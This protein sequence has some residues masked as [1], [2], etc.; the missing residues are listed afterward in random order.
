MHKRILTWVVFAL[1]AM[2]WAL[3][4]QAQDEENEGVAE[5]VMITPKA[6]QGPALEAAIR[7]FH[8]WMADKPGHFRYSWYQVQTGPHTG[9]YIA[10]TGDHNWADF[11]QEF[12]WEDEAN[13]KF[14]ADIL[15][16]VEHAERILTV[17]MKE[18]AHWPEEF[19][20]YTLFQLENWYVEPGRYG[21]FRAGLEKIH[22]AL[23]ENGY[24][25]YYGFQNTISGAKGNQITLVLPHKNYADMAEE[26]PSFYE[27]VSEALG[28]PEAFE[29]EM[30]EFGTTYHIG[31]S[32]LVR[33]LPEAS[34]YGDEE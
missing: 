21:K 7:D 34:S 4:L 24:G 3:P 19:S 13:A 33:F 30:Q 11:D 2:C 29:A 28:G 5:L 6:G 31:E 23:T 17:E 10:R 27:I 32:F 26:E 16:L 18:F 12:D 25:Q 1:A 22:K 8:H 15:P 9:N 14:E 20:E